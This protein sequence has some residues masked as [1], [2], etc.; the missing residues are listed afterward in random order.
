MQCWVWVL[1]YRDRIDKDFARKGANRISVLTKADEVSGQNSTCKNWIDLMAR[2]L[3]ISA[4]VDPSNGSSNP[5]AEEQSTSKLLEYRLEMLD[6]NTVPSFNLFQRSMIRPTFNLSSPMQIINENREIN[7]KVIK[8]D[9]EKM[10]DN[11]SANPREPI[12]S[13][14]ENGQN[15]IRCG[16]VNVS[17]GT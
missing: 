16:S 14:A 3:M 12:N 11:Q 13:I 2:N 8:D 6:P 4:G 7:D 1:Q 9:A 17:N 15:N 10:E 5:N